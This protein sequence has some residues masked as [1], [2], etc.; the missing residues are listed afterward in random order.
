MR[1]SQLC[2]VGSV[3]DVDPVDDVD[4]RRLGLVAARTALRG[5]DSDAHE[6]EETLATKHSTRTAPDL[7]H[8]MDADDPNPRGGHAAHW[9]RQTRLSEVRNSA[10]CPLGIGTHNHIR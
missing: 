5:A 7:R 3:N 2:V 8:R 1:G 4:P 10:E 6:V 9:A